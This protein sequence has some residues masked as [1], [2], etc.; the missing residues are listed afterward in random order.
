MSDVKD[1]ESSITLTDANGNKINN[2]AYASIIAMNPKK[3]KPTTLQ[4]LNYPVGGM[5]PQ[6][7][8]QSGTQSSFRNR[9][10]QTESTDVRNI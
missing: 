1:K 8:G 2:P 3:N 7:G 6:T 4:I 10:Y 5:L 9:C